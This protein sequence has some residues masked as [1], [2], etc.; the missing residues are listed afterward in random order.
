L[1][2]KHALFLNFQIAQQIA[3]KPAI[4]VLRLVGTNSGNHQKNWEKL[5]ETRGR[6]YGSSHNTLEKFSSII[7]KE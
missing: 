2:S 1:F 4:Y 3:A 6:I 5:P 7:A